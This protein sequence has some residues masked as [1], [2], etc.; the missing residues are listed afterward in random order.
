MKLYLGHISA[1]D[2]WRENDLYDRSQIIKADPSLFSAPS[3][4]LVERAKSELSNTRQPLHVVVSNG[5]K[6]RKLKNLV[7]HAIGNAVLSRSFV[8]HSPHVAVSS[9]EACFLQM[10]STMS[11]IQLIQVGFELCGTYA[12]DPDSNILLSRQPRTSIRYLTSYLQKVSGARGLTKAWQALRHIC[13]N[14]ASPME[15][16][17]TLLLCL[18]TL[19]GGYG[20]PKPIL[21][22]S[23]KV[24]EGWRIRTYRCDLAWPV[25]ERGRGS[26]H[27][28]A[29]EYD[30]HAFHNEI[31]KVHLDSKRRVSIEA[32]N[33]HVISITKQQVY[34]DFA[35][36]ELANVVAKYLGIRLRTARADFYQRRRELRKELGLLG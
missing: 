5:E 1:L 32:E 31:G 25:T 17:L 35:F 10:A 14:S 2:Y 16:K 21:N 28:L 6:R 4:K 20:L 3:R 12:V 34:D 26:Q 18:P 11:I 36:N 23:L 24:D 27:S 33:V 29:L 7:C 8:N 9:P 30:S 13:D 22:K 19:L 15:T